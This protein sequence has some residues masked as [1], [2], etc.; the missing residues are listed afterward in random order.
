M[1]TVIIRP[2]ATALSNSWTNTGGAS[3]HAVTSDSD[4][5][6]FTNNAAQN[7]TFI[8]NL[9][10]VSLSGATFN[11]WTMTLGGRK[12]G[13]G[14]ATLIARFLNTSAGISTSTSVSLTSGSFVNVAAGAASFPSGI[15]DSDVNDCIVRIDTTGGTQCFISEVFVTID[16]TA[17]SSATVHSVNGVA[18]ANIATIKGVAHANIAEV[19]TVTFD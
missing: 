8:L 12:G 4:D 7:Q 3:I 18:E 10:D 19:N 13:K 2:N 6:T 1:P 9:D 17:A 5:T 16:Y 15:D 11:S 14:S